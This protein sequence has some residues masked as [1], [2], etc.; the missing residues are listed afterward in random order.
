[1]Q[2]RHHVTPKMSKPGRDGTTSRQYPLKGLVVLLLLYSTL[3]AWAGGR[4]HQTPRT[5]DMATAIRAI[6]GL[7]PLGE[8]HRRPLTSSVVEYSVQV[9]VGPRDHDVIGLHRVVKERI[10]FAPIHASKAVL[11]A[12]GD[13]WGFDAAFLAS[14]AVPSILDSQALPV[15][16]AEHGVDVWGIDFRWTLV[17]AATTD[18]SFMQ[19]W[20]MT[21]D[22]QD[23][24]TRLTHSPPHAA[25][26][27]QRLWEN[28]PPRLESWRSDGVCLPQH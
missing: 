18:F 7:T 10:P 17:P 14:L 1:M 13:I 15:F 26:H 9:R 22:V 23:L 11:I 24:D 25:V 3:P 12:H 6:H 20:S 2:H 21:T 4:S 19:Q 28:P 8:I 27:R 16:L 5:Y